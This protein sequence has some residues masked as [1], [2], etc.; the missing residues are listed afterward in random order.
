MVRWAQGEQGE[1]TVQ[2]K[3]RNDGLEISYMRYKGDTVTPNVKPPDNYN[4]LINIL[5]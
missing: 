5:R 4:P 2:G 3:L 1:I